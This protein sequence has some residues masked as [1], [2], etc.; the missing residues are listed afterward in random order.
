VVWGGN[1][2][3][4]ANVFPIIFHKNAFLTFSFPNGQYNNGSYL[5]KT[6]AQHTQN[7]LAYDIRSSQGSVATVF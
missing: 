2:F 5:S 3:T 1:V 4:F 7:T 6:M